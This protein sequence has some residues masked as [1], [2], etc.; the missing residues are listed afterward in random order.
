MLQ[1]RLKYCT[2]A[3]LYSVGISV[4]YRIIQ[5]ILF[6]FQ[7]KYQL[8]ISLLLPVARELNIWIYDKFMDKTSKGDVSG[9][10]VISK[11]AIIVQYT[12]FL[13]YAMETVLDEVT[14]WFLMT[15]DFSINIYTCLRIVWLK[16]T[17][18]SDITRQIYLL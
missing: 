3:F 1:S 15:L 16:K 12:I 13:C 5:K 7:N 11:Y 2:I 4:Q 6:V 9:A 10:K 14:Q 18:S 17:N 8:M